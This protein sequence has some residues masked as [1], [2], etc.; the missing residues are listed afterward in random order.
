VKF[1]GD[2]LW[3]LGLANEAADAESRR[4]AKYLGKDGRPDARVY[5]FYGALVGAGA[6][7]G[8]VVGCAAQFAWA[9]S[10]CFV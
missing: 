9:L 1:P 2:G 6:A 5:A 4:G 10:C 8:G 3:Y 7:A